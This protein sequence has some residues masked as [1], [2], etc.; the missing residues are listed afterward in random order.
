MGDES[1]RLRRP[2]PWGRRR[3]TKR[4]RRVLTVAYLA[5]W[6]GWSTLVYF[7]AGDHGHVDWQEG[8][9]PIF[10]L[11]AAVTFWPVALAH[12]WLTYPADPRDMPW[13]AADDD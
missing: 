1:E 4:A 5:L 10:L 6:A 2:V 9:K 7:W 3:S 13:S 11:V 8:N 12:W